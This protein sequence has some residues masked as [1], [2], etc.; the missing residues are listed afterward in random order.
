[1][2]T[3]QMDDLLC[4]RVSYC[5][6]LEW[7]CC[8]SPLHRME[9]ISRK[10]LFWIFYYTSESSSQTI[11]LR[12]RS[13]SS[14]RKSLIMSSVDYVQ[15]DLCWRE[16][17]SK[18]NQLITIRSGGRPSFDVCQPSSM[19]SPTLQHWMNILDHVKSFNQRTKRRTSSPWPRQHTRRLSKCM[20]HST[21]ACTRDTFVGRA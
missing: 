1:M 8:L 6:L 10:S 17:K 3:T 2:D 14:L 20:L 13:K 15:I 21:I 5:A 11:Y 18:K 4:T 9:R 16:S 7:G 19:D 12:P